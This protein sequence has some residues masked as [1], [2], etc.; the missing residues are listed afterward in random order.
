MRFKIFLISFSIMFLLTAVLCILFDQPFFLNP[1]KYNLSSFIEL[2]VAV[3]ILCFLLAFACLPLLNLLKPTRPRFGRYE[4]FFL[5]STL[6]LLQIVTLVLGYFE[7]SFNKTGFADWFYYYKG[8]T[9]SWIYIVT[10]NITTVIAA[11]MYAT[12]QYKKKKTDDASKLSL[13]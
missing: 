12:Y 2:I 3:G 8:V 13:N 6:L 11:S 7:S 9:N 1:V 5:F 10:G 4:L